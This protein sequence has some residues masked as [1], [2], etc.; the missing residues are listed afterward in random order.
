MDGR[1]G[2]AASTIP[3]GPTSDTLTVWQ[4]TRMPPS[5]P[6]AAALC[7]RGW[8]EDGLWEDQLEAG[9][10]PNCAL[11]PLYFLLLFSVSDYSVLQDGSS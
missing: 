5:P 3:D 8:R 6:A 2:L 9:M 1:G 4:A 10:T 11:L 7:M